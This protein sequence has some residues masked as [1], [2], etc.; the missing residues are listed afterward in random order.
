MLADTSKKSSN[1]VEKKSMKYKTKIIIFLAVVL[2]AGAVVW[3]FSGRAG[4]DATLS[5]ADTTAAPPKI[6]PQTIAES[7]QQ[8]LDLPQ[9]F[10]HPLYKFS[11]NYPAGFTTT[12][13][14]ST[15]EGGETIVVQ[16][17]KQNAGFQIHL[18]PYDAPDTDITKERLAQDI[19]EMVVK[20]PQEVLIG[21]SGQAG[22][23]LAFIA[24]D[25]GTREV[26]FIFGGALFQLTA[27][28]ENDTLL[29]RVLGTWAFQ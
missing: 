9:T 29:Q 11:F 5:E 26:W 1:N 17:T 4:R 8:T 28:I 20:E 21:V 19:P 24:A 22:T 27:P 6:Y 12:I 7:E 13:L 2:A 14:P 10:S 18:E 25:T 23:G 15:E 16:N 3:W